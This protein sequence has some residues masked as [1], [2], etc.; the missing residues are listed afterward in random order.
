MFTRSG[1]LREEFRHPD[2]GAGT[3]GAETAA[4]ARSPEPATREPASPIAAAPAE[5]A[6]PRAGGYPDRGRAG[7]PGFMDLIGLLTEPASLY[8]REASASGRG[9]LAAD[10]Q[11]EQSLELARLH[12]DLLALLQ[13]KTAGNLGAQEKAT[14]DDVTYRL[15]LGYVEMTK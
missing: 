3:P 13:E 10:S 14:L 4:P 8:L 2:G 12:I 11:A 6:A 9:S 1:E 15:Q 5:A 7:G